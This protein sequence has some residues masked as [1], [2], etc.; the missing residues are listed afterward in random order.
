M[1]NNICFLLLIFFIIS[2]RAQET[3]KALFIGNSYT[4]SNNLPQLVSQ[5]ALSCGDTLIYDSNTP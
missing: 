3:I 2:V 1:M 4:A 5:I